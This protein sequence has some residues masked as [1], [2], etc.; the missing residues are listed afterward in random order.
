MCV[1][2][3]LVRAKAK[4]KGNKYGATRPLK[5]VK[6]FTP[7]EIPLRGNVKDSLVALALY[8]NPRHVMFWYGFE[9]VVNYGVKP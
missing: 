9:P 4:I 5:G 1:C 7:V 8:Q 6:G 3:L 2:L